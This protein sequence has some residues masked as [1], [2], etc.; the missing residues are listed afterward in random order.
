MRSW[1]LTFVF[2]SAMLAMAQATPVAAAPPHF[3]IQ[4]E[5]FMRDGKPHVIIS[6]EMHYPRIPREYWRDRLCKARAI[7]LNTI[8]TYTFWNLHEPQPGQFDF[9]G[10]LDVAAFIRLAQEEGLCRSAC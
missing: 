6:S 10:N 4:G 5:N 7:G 2:A 9:S 8:Q 1:L 3:A